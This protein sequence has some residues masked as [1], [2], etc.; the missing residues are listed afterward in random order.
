MAALERVL[1]TYCR[2]SNHI[3]ALACPD[4][5]DGFFFFCL[6]GPKMGLF[7]RQILAVLKDINHEKARTNP[8]KSGVFHTQTTKKRT[9]TIFDHFRDKPAPDYQC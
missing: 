8:P 1:L 4:R 7:D 5:S 9:N 2:L 3:G 6:F